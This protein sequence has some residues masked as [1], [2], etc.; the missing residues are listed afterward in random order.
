MGFSHACVGCHD[1]GS[2]FRGLGLTQIK[3]YALHDRGLN[4]YELRYIPELRG[5]GFSGYGFGDWHLC[6]LTLWDP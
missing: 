2:G 4:Y 6:M 1:M 3:E 5:I